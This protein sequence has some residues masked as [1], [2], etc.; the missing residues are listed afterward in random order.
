[1]PWN[2][3]I[4]VLFL[5]YIVVLLLEKYQCQCTIAVKTVSFISLFYSTGYIMHLTA[6][7]NVEEDNVIDI[8][9]YINRGA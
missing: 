1:M 6:Y 8:K 5:L 7:I 9:V 3:C 2:V 4:V